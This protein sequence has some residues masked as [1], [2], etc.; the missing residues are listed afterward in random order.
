VGD[1]DLAALSEADLQAR[2]EALKTEMRPLEKQLAELRGRRDQILT[3]RR[4]RERLD[5]REA[6]ASLRAAMTSGEL[7][8]VA[9]LVAGAEEGSFADYAYSLKTGG[10]VALGFPGAR[11]PAVAFTDGVRVVQAKD[12]RQA[13]E[14][15]SAGW[16]LGGPGR[17]GVRIHFPGTRQERLVDAADVYARLRPD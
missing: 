11:E 10:E 13:A 16:E 17:P 6:R 8:T 7:P 2:L 4:R 15:Y 9:D 5:R 12:L 1:E 14:L 3:E